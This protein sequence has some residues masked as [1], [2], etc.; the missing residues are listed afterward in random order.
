MTNTF[1]VVGDLPGGGPVR[2]ERVDWAGAKEALVANPGQ[3][4]LMAE[5]VAASIP[6]QLSTGKN[7]NFRGDELLHFEFSTRKPKDKSYPN[8]RTDL[9]GRY[10]SG[11]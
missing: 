3:W 9:Y 6:G 11:E 1:K 8:R 2:E 10:V 4:V 5:N 7:K